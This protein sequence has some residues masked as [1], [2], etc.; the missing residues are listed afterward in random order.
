MAKTATLNLSSE[1]K[2]LVVGALHENKSLMAKLQ[3]AGTSVELSAGEITVILGVIYELPHIEE[4]IKK[5]QT[6]LRA[7]G[8]N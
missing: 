1:E 4:T 3:A 8:W 5:F 2:D 7:L 6:A